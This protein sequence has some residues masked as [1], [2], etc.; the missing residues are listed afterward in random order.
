ME[1]SL[2][3]GECL[4]RKGDVE[5][6]EQHLQELVDENPDDA[7]APFVLGKMYYR[8][9]RFKDA[10]KYYEISTAKDAFNATAWLNLGVACESIKERS[11][12][13]KAYR[14]ALEINPDY[15]SALYNLGM[16]MEEKGIRFETIDL[17]ERFLKVAKPDQ[18]EF[19]DKAREIIERLQQ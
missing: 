7:M 16:L 14:K 3:F 10:I 13:L 9:N 18:Q 8:L 12:A 11:K 4:F 6:G 2:N 1:P 15:P 19:I 5:L 17:L